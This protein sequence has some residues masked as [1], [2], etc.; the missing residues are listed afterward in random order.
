MEINKQFGRWDKTNT[1]YFYD[2]VY[3]LYYDS[4][5]DPDNINHGFLPAEQKLLIDYFE[6]YPYVNNNTRGVDIYYKEAEQVI[7]IEK[8]NK[9][10]SICRQ[11]QKNSI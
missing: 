1:S 3:Q 8:I 6:P 7:R 11:K 9:L 2:V 4:H 10:A 5:K